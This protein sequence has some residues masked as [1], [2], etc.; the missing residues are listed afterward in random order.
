MKGKTC[1]GQYFLDFWMTYQE[2]NKKSPISKT[3]SSDRLFDIEN[4]VMLR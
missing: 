1:I 2:E 4:T 3:K